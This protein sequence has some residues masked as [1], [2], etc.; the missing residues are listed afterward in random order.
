V[1]LVHSRGDRWTPVAHGDRL[2]AAAQSGAQLQR[3]TLT[4]ADHTHGMR[5]EREAYWPAVHEFLTSP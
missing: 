3:L 5:D 2:A 1:L 4:H